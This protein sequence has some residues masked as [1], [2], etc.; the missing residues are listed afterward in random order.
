VH[1]RYDGI[2]DRFSVYASYP[3]AL[4]LWSP[5]VAAFS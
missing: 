5:L 3:S 1:R 2:V 4:D